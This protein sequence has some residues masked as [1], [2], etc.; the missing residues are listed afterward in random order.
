MNKLYLSFSYTWVIFHRS[1][2]TFYWST[3]FQYL[4]FS[5]TAWEFKSNHSYYIDRL[6]GWKKCFFEYVLSW[7]FLQKFEKSFQSIISPF[8]QVSRM[9]LLRDVLQRLESS[10]AS[11]QS[12]S[13][14]QRLQAG[15]AAVTFLERAGLRGTQ[16][17]GIIQRCGGGGFC[18]VLLVRLTARCGGLAEELRVAWAPGITSAWRCV[19]VRP[20]DSPCERER[21]TPTD[22]Y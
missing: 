10:S 7:L 20:G 14:M 11:T 5:T 22:L 1:C 2:Y 18:K 6:S 9:Q 16:M 4:T 12:T 8:P 15:P 19:V 13:C 3:D 17:M 21:G